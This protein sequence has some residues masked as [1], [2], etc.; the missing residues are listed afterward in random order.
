MGIGILFFF[1]DEE[2]LEYF[3]NQE[4]LG[5]PNM[6]VIRYGKYFRYQRKFRSIPI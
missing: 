1:F 5:Y 2:V 4:R 3:A 6:I